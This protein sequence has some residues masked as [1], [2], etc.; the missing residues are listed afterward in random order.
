M[1]QDEKTFAE[2]R[3]SAKDRGWNETLGKIEAAL[4][5]VSDAYIRFQVEVNAFQTSCVR[6]ARKVSPD[7]SQKTMTCHSFNCFSQ[8]QTDQSSVQVSAFPQLTMSL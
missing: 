2:K 5:D 8:F 3:F 7:W 4:L 6:A 1:L